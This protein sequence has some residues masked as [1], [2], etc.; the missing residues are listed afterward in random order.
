MIGRKRKKVFMQGIDVS[1]F[2]GNIDWVKV[3]NDD[4]RF[5]VIKA[6][7]GKRDSRLTGYLGSFTDSTFVRN[8]TGARAAGLDTSVYH[9]FTATS[10]SE[11]VKEADYFLKVIEPYKSKITSYAAVDV[12]SEVWLKGMLPAVLAECVDA[13]CQR[14]YARGFQPLVYTNPNYLCYKLPASFR[15]QHDIWLAHWGVSSP[16]HVPN[17]KMWQYG[18]G[19]VDGISVNVDLDV[20]YYEIRDVKPKYE[21]G[22][23]YTI[24]VGDVYS[25]GK[26]VPSRLAGR[27]Y[28]ILAVKPDMIL[29]GGIV[30]WVKI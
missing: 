23:R 14:V 1:V 30:S 17:M 18:A 29:L 7:Q 28:E 8:I 11:A 10:V 6:T 21:V 26:Q 9:Y 22:G 2:Q 16:F 19:R 3:K 25:N 13:F 4:V 20:G 15:Q 5:A 12:E 27:T 24:K